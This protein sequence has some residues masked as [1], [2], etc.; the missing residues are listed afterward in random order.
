MKTQ[1]FVIVADESGNELKRAK[2]WDISSVDGLIGALMRTGLG[3]N[4]AIE[5]GREVYGDY[6]AIDHPRGTDE[7]QDETEHS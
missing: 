4:R 3:A 5:I 1:T 2:L 7:N 6:G